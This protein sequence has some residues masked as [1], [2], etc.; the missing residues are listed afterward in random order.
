MFLW[1]LRWVS[2]GYTETLRESRQ[3]MAGKGSVFTMVSCVLVIF[4]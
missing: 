3:M 4:S 2:C 1:A